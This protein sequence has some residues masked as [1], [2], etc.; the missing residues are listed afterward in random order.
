MTP[1]RLNVSVFPGGFNLPM[2]VAIQQNFF[3]DENLEV[4][5]H[6]TGN[7]VE[8]L[9]GLATSRYEIAMTAFDNIVAY[10]EGQGE[11]DLGQIPDLFAFMGS[12]NA[13]LSLAVRPEVRSYSDLKGKTL[14]V[15]ALTTGFAF[16]L[17]KMLQLNG[18]DEGE[19]TFERAGG[20]LQRFEKLKNGAF[21]GTLVVTPFDELSVRAGCAVLQQ[22]WEAIPNYQG[23]VGA[24]RREWA[25]RNTDVLVQF[26]IAYRRALRWMLRSENHQDL[27]RLLAANVSGMDGTL[28]RTV[29]T[30]FLDSRWGFEPDARLHADGMSTVLSLRSEYGT[31]QKNLVDISRYIDSR[32]YENAQRAFP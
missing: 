5:L 31:P 19:V 28:V 23:V 17:R 18:V 27:E 16:V 7:S 30:K 11:V 9:S 26:I 22:A 32:F 15:D 13:F 4:V 10:D 8:Q 20:V 12:D 29:L 24:A 21:A 3:A 14:A 2:W 25:A 6:Q 1:A